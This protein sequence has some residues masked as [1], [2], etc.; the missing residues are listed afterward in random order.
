MRG[1]GNPIAKGASVTIGSSRP[2]PLN[3]SKGHGTIRRPPRTIGEGVL[4]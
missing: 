3:L 1:T 2:T 4:P